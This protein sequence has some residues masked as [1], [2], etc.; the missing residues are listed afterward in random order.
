MAKGD[1]RA[2]EIK[3]VTIVG[4]GTMGAGIASVVISA[5]FKANLIDISEELLKKAEKAVEKILSR[6]VEKG[7]MTEA[8]KACALGNIS[9]RTDLNKAASSQLII[10]AVNENI[11]IKKKV[12]S[13]LAG[14]V[15]DDAIIGSNT[16]ALK[17]SELAA[18]IRWPDKVIGMHFFNPVPAMKLIELVKTDLTSEQTF[19]IAKQFVGKLGKEA[20]TVKESP[21]F[22][23]NRVLI[24]MINEAA[25]L[26]GEKVATAEDIDKAMALGANHPIGPLALADLIGLDICLAIMETLKE[27]LKSD[28]YEPAPAL[29]ELVAAGKLGKKSGSGFHNYK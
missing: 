16:S 8:D 1:F 18:A 21:G 3:E 12:F 24:P 2:M 25:I 28:K 9:Y 15:S 11:D 5:G 27:Q 13:Q 10:E 26:F 17:I 23:V 29:R 7:K 4:A 20:V 22:I 19:N 14:I 6:S